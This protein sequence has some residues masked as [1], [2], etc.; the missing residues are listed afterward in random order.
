MG[1]EHRAW[2]QEQEQKA[3]GQSTNQTLWEAAQVQSGG[4]R[5]ASLSLVTHINVTLS[6]LHRLQT[7]ILKKISACHLG[8]EQFND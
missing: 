8:G 7:S 3:S 1:G 4:G 6:D 5:G 2:S